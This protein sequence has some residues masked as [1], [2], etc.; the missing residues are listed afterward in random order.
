MEQ[1]EKQRSRGTEGFGV[2]NGTHLVKAAM[3]K[4]IKRWLKKPAND[5]D[6]LLFHHRYPTSTI[7][8]RKASHP[9][10]T[11]D[12]F[13]DTQYVLIHNGGV[14]N[15]DDLFEK[16]QE[17]GIDYTS[18]LNDLTFNDSEALLWDFALT[19]EGKQDK[20]TAYGGIAFV[21]I[22]MTGGVVDK[23]YFAKNYSKPLNLKREK[24][25]IMISSEGPG[26]AIKDDQLYTYN[27]KLN[28]LTTRYF[29]VPSYDP[30]YRSV[31][32]PSY[33]TSQ[34]SGSWSTASQWDNEGREFHFDHNGLAVY[35]DDELWTM[36]T[37]W[38]PHATETVGEAIRRR[39]FADNA[40]TESLDSKAYT[41]LCSYLR[42][43]RGHYE[44]AYWAMEA[45][46][47]DFEMDPP[48]L[49]RTD[50]LNLI[51]RAIDLMIEDEDFVDENSVN[52]LWDMLGEDNT[53]L[54]L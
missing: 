28:R 29:K 50:M 31:Q 44:S 27:Y 46:Y 22:K 15:A 26:E 25:G 34:Y 12:Y 21:A 24:L 13:G 10:S 17:L 36:S 37:G 6:M 38:D 16:H 2:F 11:G 41:L 39:Q 5:S 14:W 49:E 3:E 48:S 35:E 1:F 47:Q 30:N 18:F 43:S 7:N 45:D 23:L 4:R 51:E 20:L 54:A 9:F 52:L 8:V 32:S 40:P 53:N 42:D 19:M 33:P